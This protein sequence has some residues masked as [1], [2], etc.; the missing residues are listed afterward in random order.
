MCFVQKETGDI[1]NDSDAIANEAKHFFYEN[2]YASRENEIM[3]SD[4]G[5]LINIQSLSLKQS[6]NLEVLISRQEAL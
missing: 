5:I 3:D 4:V 2:V 1:I 6:N